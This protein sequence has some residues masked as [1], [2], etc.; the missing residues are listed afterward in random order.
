MASGHRLDASF[1]GDPAVGDNGPQ[2]YTALLRTDT[3]GFSKLDKYGGHNQT[4]RYAGAV[5]PNWLVEASFARAKNSI[6]EI[7]SVD[8][9]SVDRQHRHAA[10]TQ[11]RHRLLRGRQ[12][13]C[14][15]AV[16]GQGH[17][18]APQAQHPLRRRIREHRLRQH[19]QSDGSDVHAAGR[20]ADG[21]RR[22]RSTSIADPDFGRIFRVVR[23]N[24]SNVR[25]T[26]QHY[27][28]LFAQDT[29]THRQ[30]ADDQSRHPLRASVA[31]RY[32]VG[33]DARQ[34]LGAAHRCDVRSD[35]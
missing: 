5:K 34:Q 31:D 11:R 12:Q 23:A 27:V 26:H 1:F 33:P 7:P 13:W 6:V 18:C 22:R 14:Q 19:D 16:R 32:L 3:S 20:H 24:T 28:T 8:Q 4:V 17:Q 21:N 2:R 9:W 30:P 29:W 35:R 10:D 15:L 25:D